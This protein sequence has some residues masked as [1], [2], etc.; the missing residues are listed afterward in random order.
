M[1]KYIFLVLILEATSSCSTQKNRFLNREY[2]SINTKFNVL[3]N[4]QEALDI[5]TAILESQAQDNFLSTLPVELITLDGEDQ[6]V[7]ASIPSF[8][9]AEDKAVKAIQK[10]TMSFKGVQKNS[11]INKAYLL[12]GKARYYDRRFLPA[13]EAFNF[14]LGLYSE[15]DVFYEGKLWREK[16]N[17]R[18]GNDEL[19]ISN[20]KPLANNISKKNKLYAEVNATLAQ[21]FLNIKAKD[22]ALKFIKRA[23]SYEKDKNLQTR[24]RFI[25]AQIFEE[26]NQ[27]ESAQLAFNSIVEL[28][29]KSP[30][31]Y[32]MHAK[33]NVLRIKSELSGESPE[34][35]LQKLSD[36]FENQQFNH[37]IYRQLAQYNLAQGLDS[38]AK[39]FYDKSTKATID[40]PTLRQNYRDLA[41]N[42]FFR[43]KYVE[44]GAYLDSLLSQYPQETRQ[45]T[46]VLR[47]REGLEDVVNFEK[48]ITVTDS[49][50]TLTEMIPEE[51]LAYFQKAINIKRA[52]ELA[53]IELKKRSLFNVMNRSSGRQFYF[54]NKNLVVIGKQ[55]FASTFGNRPNVDNWNRI[56][57]LKGVIV[58]GQNESQK[59]KGQAVIVKDN[60][61]AYVDL[62][63]TDSIFINSLRTQRNQAY[64]EVG[65]IYKEKFKNKT[66]A[67]D[68]LNKL[69]INNPSE[70]QE[71]NAWYHLYKM[72]K[73]S[74]I[75]IDSN[76]KDKILQN[77]PES[78]FARIIRDPE[79]FKLRPNETPTTR[80][81]TLYSLF[82][83][84]KYEE[85]I[86]K[87]DDLLVV[88]SGT[89]MVS[90]V[91]HLMANASG[92][93]DGIESWKEKLKGIIR[94]YPNSEA[95]LAS[96]KTLKG[97]DDVAQGK[98]LENGHKNYK[99]IFPIL[100]ENK[101]Q[102]T[103]LISLVTNT[104]L[105]TNVSFRSLSKEVY[106]RKYIF[107]VING[108]REKP[109]I[110]FD[111]PNKTEVVLLGAI[112]NKFVVLSSQ[113]RDIQLF[114]SWNVSQKP[115]SY[116]KQRTKRTAQ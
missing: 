109:N 6:N 82:L 47:E 79:N 7:S 44:T 2:H 86:T 1:L 77:Y 98:G 73:E 50:L 8:I 20:L 75:N 90:K 41:D 102:L 88:F 61:Q 116:E 64:L 70:T 100:K 67:A 26:L 81:E 96:N 45:K 14:L 92:R 58:F 97:L 23:A 84:Q 28:N 32:W 76:F 4:G 51:Q 80:Y 18:L 21:A 112:S 37:L 16:T 107:V 95:A 85:V 59:A 115:I 52:K 106:N 46:I 40:Q 24:Y 48:I 55:E 108:L 69:L 94:Y 35:A 17:L 114:K 29:R 56:E 65:I 57:Y 99:L 25:E 43:G 3:F 12:L 103:K 10:H 11:Q 104:L 71:L 74:T 87:G 105:A 78:R 62:L 27:K 111:L 113:Y 66:L 72:E 36:A 91:A 54:Y 49:I 42:A 53:Q 34:K 83:E 89:T 13:I 60:A 19:A 101:S 68:R 63:P 9:R 22:S 30:R 5:G 38:V 93:L 39:V 33:L 15:T 110:V 31:L